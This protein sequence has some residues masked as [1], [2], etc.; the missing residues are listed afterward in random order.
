[1]TGSPSP[2]VQMLPTIVFTADGIA[3]SLDGPDGLAFDPSGNLWVSNLQSDNAGSVVEFTP[4]QLAVVGNLSPTVFL[5]SDI[6]GLNF[7]QPSLL[8]F[9][10]IP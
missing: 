2:V 1:V 10:P 4:A 7:H 8:T 9:G 6:F 3:L 5:D